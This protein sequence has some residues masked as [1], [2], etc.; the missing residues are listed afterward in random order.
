MYIYRHRE[1]AAMYPWPTAQALMRS[2]RKKSL[3]ELPGNIVELANLFDT[4]RLPLFTCCDVS[5]FQGCVR[6]IEGKYSAIFACKNLF[7]AVTLQQCNEI[8]ADATFK[9]MANNMGYQMLSIH[10]MVQNYVSFVIFC[11]KLSQ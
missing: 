5:V 8:H 10:C 11:F 6:D 4:D 3:P 9:I 7:R 1:A 2:V